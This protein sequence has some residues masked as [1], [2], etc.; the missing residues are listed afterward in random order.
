M[1]LLRTIL[2]DNILIL[3]LQMLE[4]YIFLGEDCESL[5]NRSDKETAVRILWAKLGP[6]DSH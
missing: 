1:G 3:T 2:S 5:L 6:H 4:I